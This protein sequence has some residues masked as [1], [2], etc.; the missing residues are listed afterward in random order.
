MGFDLVLFLVDDELV[1]ADHRLVA[2]LLAQRGLVGEIGD[3]FL[4]PAFL[5]QL[6]RA[7]IGVD[8]VEDFENALLVFVGEDSRR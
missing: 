3:L 1:D 2:A 4:E 5:D 6:D 7:A 8:I